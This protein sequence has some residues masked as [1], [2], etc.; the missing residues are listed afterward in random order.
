MH[1]A[2]RLDLRP[3]ARAAV[4]GILGLRVLGVGSLASGALVWWLVLGS[5]ALAGPMNVA[6]AAVGALVLAAPGL[7]LLHF[8][9]SLWRAALML[10]ELADRSAAGERVDGPPGFFFR[11][12]RLAMRRRGIGLLATPWYWAAAAWGFGASVV[13]VLAACALTI[14]AII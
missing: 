7:L 8:Q 14:T 3:A 9:W 12:M 1:E 2:P 10:A 4:K 13:L 6:V 11:S 5:T